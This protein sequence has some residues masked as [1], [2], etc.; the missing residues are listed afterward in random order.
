MTK[1][2]LTIFALVSLLALPLFGEPKCQGHGMR[3]VSQTGVTLP[4][5]DGRWVNE[6]GD[7]GMTGDFDFSLADSFSVP[8]GTAGIHALNRN[9]GDARYGILFGSNIWDAQQTFNYDIVAKAQIQAADG[10]KT[11]PTVAFSDGTDWDSGFYA[12]A[13]KGLTVIRLSANDTE[14]ANFDN[15]TFT[16]L[17]DFNNNGS[18][19][20]GDAVGDFITIN[21]GTWTS[22]NPFTWNIDGNSI[23]AANGQSM[24]MNANSW[25]FTGALTSNGVNGIDYDPGSDT[26]ADI[27][28]IGVTGT[29]TIKWDE[30]DDRFE[31]TK[32][33]L[34]PGGTPLMVMFSGDSSPHFTTTSG[35]YVQAGVFYF[36]GTTAGG[37]PASVKVVGYKDANPT[38]WDVLLYDLTNS[39]QIAEKTG[40]TGTASEIIDIGTLSNL[41]ASAAMFEVQLKRTGGAGFNVY[42]QSLAVLF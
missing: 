40:N 41:P 24:T 2:L 27:A 14:V 37:T 26:D 17:I 5:G 21:A 33:F 28:T 3:I 42:V 29:P 7:S 32:Q 8:L 6:T 16:N 4:V 1:K 20:L 18:T 19:V 12:D 39:L 9:A 15:A 30:G 23:F 34:A 38:S 31:S 22:Q 35:T 36:P 11:L 10:T 25:S 13:S